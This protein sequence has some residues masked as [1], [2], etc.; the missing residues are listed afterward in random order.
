MTVGS[1]DEPTPRPLDLETLDLT[2]QLPSILKAVLSSPP[3]KSDNTLA[4]SWLVLLGHTIL[5]MHDADEVA[6]TIE[7]P[8]AWKAAWTFVDNG[9]GSIRA[10]AAQ[11]LELI[12]GAFT[13]E[14]VAPA[15][16]E[17]STIASN[18]DAASVLGRI[19]V[20]LTKAFDQLSFASSIPQLLSI[21][22]SLLSALRPPVQ[23]PLGGQS[24]AELLLL[25]LVIYIANLRTKKTFEHKEA[26][27]RVLGVAMAVL[28]PHV[29][30][31]PDVLPLN[32]EP[33]DRA[34]GKE[35]R[36]F[37]LPLLQHAHPS[38]LAHFV[39]YFVPLSE[40]MFDLQGDAEMAGREAEAKVWSVMIG[41]V[42]SGLIGYC[43]V[44]RDLPTVR[45]LFVRG[46]RRNQWADDNFL[47]SHACLCPVAQPA[48]L[49]SAGSSASSPSRPEGH[50]RIQCRRRILTCA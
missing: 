7:I 16:K 10:A 38:P 45:C 22:A 41:Q 21:L 11:C 15:L 24:P 5:V 49:Q 9:D 23:S 34:A 46:G 39:S 42:W 50:G 17:A 37:L 31:S 2:P 3:S 28:G 32:L 48:T 12:S 29:V 26:V 20:Q 35:P 13:P 43:H 30:L 4:P 33:I 14:F 19:I 6:C 27:D 1:S 47:G 8:K 40:R 36:A 44:T 18:G 25:P